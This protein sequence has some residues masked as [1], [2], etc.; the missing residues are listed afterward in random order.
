MRLMFILQCI[1]GFQSQRIDFKNFFSRAY[2]PS[3]DPVSIELPRDFKSEG[4]K[5]DVV[6]R[7]KKIL[8]GQAEAVRLWYENFRN[9]LVDLISVVSKV[10]PCMFISNTVVFLVYVDGCLFWARSQSDIGNVMKSFKEDGSSYNWRKSKGDSV[11]DFLGIDI[12]TLDG[13]VF[14]F[15]QTSLIHKVLEATGVE[16]CNR[17]TTPTKVVA[18]LGTDDNGYEAEKYCTNSYSFFIGIMSYLE[19]NTIPYISFAV[20]QRAH[21]IHNTKESHDMAVRRICRYIQGTK[22]NGLVFNPY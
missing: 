6:L 21:F 1:L 17:L 8:Y 22:E 3:G 14:Q 15:Y 7:L 16:H 9:G 18:P 13:V 19:S 10:D 5:C 11:P 2:I 20:H 12:K 4:V